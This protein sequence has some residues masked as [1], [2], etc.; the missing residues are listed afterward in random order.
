MP[1]SNYPFVDINGTGIPKPALPVILINPANGFSQF[2]WALIDTGADSTVI[3]GFIAKA[4]YHDITHRSVQRDV[5]LGISGTTITYHHTFRLRVLGLNRKGDVLHDKI[6]IKMNKRK[7]AVIQRLHQMV[8]G[9]NDFLK[10]Y[11][12]TINYPKKI[13]SLQ[14]P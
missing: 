6:A 13:F 12:L 4:L 14:L 11:N 8:V 5:C 2:T 3:P 10:R 1:I 9:E 7:F